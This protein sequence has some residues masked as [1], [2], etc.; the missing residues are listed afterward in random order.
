MSLA[1]CFLAK[2]GFA[3]Q[4]L[5]RVTM[6]KFP[7]FSGAPV[8]LDD[9][10]TLDALRGSDIVKKAIAER[11]NSVLAVRK[12][13]AAKLTK[14]KAD[15]DVRF[16]KQRAEFEAARDDALA[17]EIE[18]RRAQDRACGLQ[19]KLS[20]D[21]W[22]LMND[23]E[24][25]EAQLA[26]TA[27]TEIQLFIV[28]MWAMWEDAAKELGTREVVET[29]RRLLDSKKYVTV[30]NLASVL[31][32]REAIRDAIAAAEKMRLDID[33]STVSARLEQLH[34]ALPAIERV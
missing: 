22:T 33:Q 12:T 19:S 6:N 4:I 3:D 32:R 14:L 18:W 10:S 15:A 8:P 13:A 21:S 17:A 1:I 24:T 9:R 2:S 11:D 16:P 25:I 7:M 34:Q 29:S 28:S 27:S 5:P 31:A 30:S 26:E 23:V 20:A